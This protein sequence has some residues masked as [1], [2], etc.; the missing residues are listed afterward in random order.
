MATT[1]QNT[2]TADGC[3]TTRSCWFQP[4]GC[5]KIN[6]ANCVSIVQWVSDVDGVDFEFQATM[7]DLNDTSLGHWVAIG[8]SKDDRMVGLL[9][10]L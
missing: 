2:L 8:F 3:G 1:A 5:E 10:Y 6:V 7:Q 4:E 9:A